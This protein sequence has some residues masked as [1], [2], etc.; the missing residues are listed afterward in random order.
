MFTFS[1][2]Y[3]FLD[4]VAFAQEAGSFVSCCKSMNHV[5]PDSIGSAAELINQLVRLS[6]GGDGCN[7]PSFFFVSRAAV[8]S[9]H[10]KPDLLIT[11]L[12]IRVQ[13][14]MLSLR[15]Y[16]N[17]TKEQNHEKNADSLDSRGNHFAGA[18]RNNCYGRW[19]RPLAYVFAR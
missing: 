10:G 5:A 13:R 4:A 2:G 19:S 12:L 7:F 8:T 9:C 18:V 6:A 17:S 15:V 14:I 3:R 11:S 16:K 1:P